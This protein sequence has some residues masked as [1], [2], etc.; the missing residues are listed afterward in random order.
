MEIHV[1]VSLICSFFQVFN[2]DGIIHFCFPYRNYKHSNR[3]R[4]TLGHAYNTVSFTLESDEK[5]SHSDWFSMLLTIIRRRLTLFGATQ[6][7]VRCC[8]DTKLECVVEQ[9]RSKCTRSTKKQQQHRQ[10]QRRYD[11]RTQKQQDSSSE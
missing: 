7:S 1:K 10:Q 3:S 8:P 5:P 11:Q 6:Y 9:C 4:H 2:Y